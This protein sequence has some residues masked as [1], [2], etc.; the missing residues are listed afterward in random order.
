[1]TKTRQAAMVMVVVVQ[2]LT[3]CDR[4]G[5]PH[6]LAPSSPVP[7]AAPQP[8][9]APTLLRFAEPGGFSTTE[10]RDAQDDIVQINSAGVLIWTADETRFPGYSV[11]AVRS[12]YSPYITPAE[13]LCGCWLEVRF[14]TKDGERRAYLT[15]EYGHY[16]PG[17]L[18]DLA[19]TD[20]GLTMI[21]TSVYPPGTPTLSGVV[22]EMTSRG[23]VP[24]EGVYVAR[25]VFGGWREAR[26]DATGSYAIQGLSDGIA[27]VSV[28]KEGFRTEERTVSITGD[29]RFD[30]QLVRR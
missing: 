22:T 1:M 20:G 7:D 9:S 8:G 10:L 15:A 4:D 12:L 27:V 17:T 2:A 29:T 5:R 6:P 25:E 13:S 23:P 26:T 28:G 19:R 30:L 16:N 11:P 14:G 18:V 3:G 21:Q 24:L